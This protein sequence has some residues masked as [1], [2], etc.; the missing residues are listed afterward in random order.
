MPIEGLDSR[1]QFAI[2]AA[3]YKDLGVGADG[4]LKDGQGTRGH[5][6][7]FQLRDLI[8]AGSVAGQYMW[9]GDL[10]RVGLEE[11]YGASVNTRELVARLVEQISGF[12]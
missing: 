10:G 5:F 7:F 3:R 11:I 12:E 9:R 2:V 4:G 6:V 8:F 1:Q